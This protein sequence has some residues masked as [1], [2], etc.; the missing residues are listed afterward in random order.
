MRISALRQPHSSTGPTFSAAA[1]P[2]DAQCVLE[3]RTRTTYGALHHVQSLEGGDL[4]AERYDA[5]I[6]HA[7]S[8]SAPTVAHQ[9]LTA[10]VR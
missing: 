8:A 2:A 4:F 5:A 10:T 1:G 6:D 3:R 9:G 7:D